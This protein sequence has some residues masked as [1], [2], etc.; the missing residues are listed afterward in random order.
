MRTLSFI[1]TLIISLIFISSPLWWRIDDENRGRNIHVDTSVSSLRPLSV[2]PDRTHINIG[3]SL[4]TT[5]HLVDESDM[6]RQG[7][8]LWVELVNS[9]GG[10]T[11][12]S[13]SYPVRLIELNDD[14][15]PT[16]IAPNYEDLILK[17]QVDFLFAP[18][19]STLTMEARKVAE[20][21]GVIL[22][23]ASG[24]SE[25]IYN[26]NNRC[27]FAALTSASWYTKDFFDMVSKL[28][29]P[30]K[31]FAVLTTKRLFAKSVG[32]GARIWGLQKQLSEVYFK[33]LP[34]LTSNFVP[35][36]KEI[37]HR[38]PDLLIFAGHSQDALLFTRQ[39][40][41]ST[42]I[43]PKAVIMPLGPSQNNYSTTLGTASEGMIGMTQWLSDSQWTGEIFGSATDFSH[44]FQKKYGHIP[45]YQSAQAAACGVILQQALQ[46][47]PVFDAEAIVQSIRQ[48]DIETFYGPVKYDQRGL[49]IRKPMA[50]VQ[51]QNNTSVAIWPPKE[52]KSKLRY[53][54]QKN[55]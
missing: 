42:T 55:L 34:E 31:S 35:Y 36:L 24:A 27:T 10:I 47:S 19:S 13:T 52:A 45:S 23:V 30:P 4:S 18:Y 53:P 26:S 15:T 29:P 25:K 48:L 1:V 33:S 38:K 17:K 44:L 9:R 49:N 11:I 32:K 22:L 2:D 3:V 7:F 51:I 20:K 40:R 50:L 28:N 39:L 54:L 21:Y 6:T 14:S 37:E 46:Q 43:L 16:T 8:L 41:Q 5:G 12:G